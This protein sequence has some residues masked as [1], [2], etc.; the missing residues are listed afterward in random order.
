MPSS[1]QILAGLTIL[2]NDWQ[3]VAVGWHL[4]LA[5]LLL[6]MCVGWRPS[7]RLLWI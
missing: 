3:L 2:T 1:G 7:K 6:G 5:G 4:L